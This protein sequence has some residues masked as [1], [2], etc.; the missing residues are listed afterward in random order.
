MVR[1]TCSL[2][3][4]AIACAAAAVAFNVSAQTPGT[5]DTSFG[6][7]GFVTT[8]VSASTGDDRARAMVVQPDG[9]IVVGGGCENDFCLVRYLPNG[10][11]DGTF[12]IGGKITQSLL[13]R[14]IV[15]VLALQPNDKLVMVGACR[16][17]AN[18]YGQMCAARFTATG[19]LDPT[20]GAGVGWVIVNFTGVGAIA[21][22]VALQSDGCIVMADGCSG[23]GSS[24]GATSVWRGLM[25]L[26]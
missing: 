13:G 6:A 21:R 23:I 20:F 15:Y 8:P 9:K 2:F 1:S 12:G 7:T 3:R 18:V 11:L 16:L 24:T 17:P 14:G 10:S 4:V 5:L 26:A 25:P 22:A 19:A